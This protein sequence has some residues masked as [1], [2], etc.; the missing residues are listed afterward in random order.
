MKLSLSCRGD[1][2]L[3]HTNTKY[4]TMGFNNDTHYFITMYSSVA[5]QCLATLTHYWSR[6]TGAGI[7]FTSEFRSKPF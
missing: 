6:L 4:K 7:A 5:Q 1:T 3:M 2:V